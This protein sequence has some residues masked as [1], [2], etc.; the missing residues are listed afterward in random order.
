MHDP[1]THFT[2]GMVSA[3]FIAILIILLGLGSIAQAAEE[4]DKKIPRASQLREDRETCRM[5]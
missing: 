3:V 1:R 4:P 2:T 5:G